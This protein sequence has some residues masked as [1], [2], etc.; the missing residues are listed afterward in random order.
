MQSV[1]GQEE[2]SHVRREGEEE[3]RGGSDGRRGKRACA[4]ASAAACDPAAG[5]A[6][7][8]RGHGRGRTASGA[9]HG[10]CARGG[11]ARRGTRLGCA[12]FLAGAR[13]RAGAR[14]RGRIRPRR[15][16]ARDGGGSA[17]LA[18]GGA[19]LRDGRAAAAA[20]GTATGTLTTEVD[21][22]LR[23][24]LLG[25]DANGPI[26][27][28]WLVAGHCARRMARSCYLFS[29]LRM[30]VGVNRRAAV[31]GTHTGQWCMLSMHGCMGS[32]TLACQGWAY[33]WTAVSSLVL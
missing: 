6:A 10:C 21:A 4:G 14:R 12:R 1:C 22:A 29:A 11:C 19:A 28:F 24:L 15:R 30:R 9:G 33:T 2:G 18:R 5:P 27:V 13:F 17:R 16:A 7:H 3:P 32:R 20:C 26:R 31:A 8:G 23:L 25:N